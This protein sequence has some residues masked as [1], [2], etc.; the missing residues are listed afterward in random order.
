MRL[1]LDFDG[2]LAPIRADP[3][4]VHPRS[5]VRRTL[6]RLVGLSKLS[7]AVVS[8]RQ[9]ADVRRRVAVE[10]VTYV[11]NHGLEVAMDGERV[12]HPGA[13]A[14][15]PRIERLR[16]RLTARLSSVPG[17]F[18]EDK[19]LSL[20]VHYREATAERAEEVRDVVRG[21]VEGDACEVTAGKEILEVRP[22]VEWGKG[23]A[24]DLLRSAGSGDPF[25]LY[26]GDD[27]TDEH[28]FRA[29]EEGVGVRVGRGPTA[30][31]YRLEGPAD[32]LGLLR[33]LARRWS[34]S[35]ATPV[36][37]GTRPVAG[38]ERPDP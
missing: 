35:P 3:D 16:E 20:T 15:E 21:T 34:V 36:R 9:L 7:V 31:D 1:C 4:R 37:R 12:V 2:T 11:G 26:V 13:A 17:C 30:A 19:R 33:W 5:G 23:D 24:V 8:G 27:E 28:A 22:A 25:V 6:R 32:V 38:L 14:A 18:V 29:L 10:G